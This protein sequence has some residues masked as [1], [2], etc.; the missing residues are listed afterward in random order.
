MCTP[1]NLLGNYGDELQVA[2]RLHILTEEANFKPTASDRLILKT[3]LTN[4]ATS[5]YLRI[6]AAFFLL[7][8][9][10]DARSLLTNWVASTNL[11]Q[12]FNAARAIQWFSARANGEARDWAGLELV[13]MLQTRCLELPPGEYQSSDGYE[14][15]G[16]DMMDDAWTPLSY[17]VFTLGELKER[18]AIPALQ[19]M[20]ERNEYSD[21]AAYALGRMV[22]GTVPDQR[23][24]DRLVGDAISSDSTLVRRN[25]IETLRR[26]GHKKCLLAL[27]S[28]IDTNAPAPTK[29]DKVA[30][31][32]GEPSDY[33]K[34]HALRALR[35]ATH[36]DFEGNPEKWR[37]W[38]ME[39]ASQ[40]R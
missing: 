10:W 8:A 30:V 2:W 38:I 26:N 9:D 37:R 22:D 34:K 7:D 29:F 1:T 36:Q 28:I 21:A 12:R 40:V 19:S 31:L 35:D 18:R 32:E 14:K 17:V 33:S 13:K 39:N 3:L 20:I 11:R 25:T 24:I 4:E 23:E 16:Y 27:V 5:V 6:C 15:N